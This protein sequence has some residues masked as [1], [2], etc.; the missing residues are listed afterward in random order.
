[1][2][3]AQTERGVCAIKF[4]VPGAL[5]AELRAEYPRARSRGTMP[6]SHRCWAG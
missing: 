4:G 6:R 1:M 2:L 5:E 3:I